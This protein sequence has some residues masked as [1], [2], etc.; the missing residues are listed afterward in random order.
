MLPARRVDL[1]HL[2]AFV[3]LLPGG[4]QD[5]HGVLVDAVKA[6]GIEVSSFD[7]EGGD[8]RDY[9]DTAVWD[10]VCSELGHL[11]RSTCGAYAKGRR[12]PTT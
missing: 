7:W 1:E 9:A 2:V 5:K 11:A 12:G 8:D 6:R 10:K 4:R 3:V